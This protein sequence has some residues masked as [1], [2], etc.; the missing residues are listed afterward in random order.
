MVNSHLAIF[1]SKTINIALDKVLSES[2]LPCHNVAI[3]V[4]S[5]SCGN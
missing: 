1:A 4:P 5:G 3:K 2:D